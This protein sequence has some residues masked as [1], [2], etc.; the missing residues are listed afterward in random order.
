MNYV[1]KKVIDIMEELYQDRI[2]MDSCD[3]FN[4][5]E[6]DI[7]EYY[8]THLSVTLAQLA[9]LTGRSVSEL[10]CILMVG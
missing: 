3:P 7:R 10:K 8:D 9:L 1:T 2:T 5:S 4:W 6:A